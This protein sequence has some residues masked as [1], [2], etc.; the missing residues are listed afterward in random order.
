[1]ISPHEPR[2]FEAEGREDNLG[3][4][5]IPYVSTIAFSKSRGKCH[6]AYLEDA[7]RDDAGDVKRYGELQT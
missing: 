3:I 2:S 6:K 5:P 7:L 4:Y 1:M